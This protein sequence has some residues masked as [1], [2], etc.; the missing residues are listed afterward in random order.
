[1]FN[2]PVQTKHS[3]APLF[4]VI[5][6]II[7]ALSEPMSSELFAY[8]RQQLNGFQW[9]RLITGH[10]LHTNTVHLLLNTAGLTLLWALHGHYYQTS[11][12][13]IIFLLLCLGTSGGL[14]LFAPQMQWYVGLSGVLHGLFIIGAYFDIHNKF[15]TGWIL[16][17]GVWIKVLHEQIYGA[18]EDVAQLIAA[19]VA[20]DAHLFGTITG[21]IIIM[22]YFILDKIRTKKELS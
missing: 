13:L 8:D 5:V 14:Y 2:L 9:W 12:Y 1:M 11:R 18:S 15:K 6:S 4:I 16:L 22:Y 3:L 19:N 20:V 7:L 17:I 10:F 21:S